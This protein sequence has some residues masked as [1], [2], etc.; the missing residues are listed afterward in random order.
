M[1]NGS[2][3]AVGSMERWPAERWGM[4]GRDNFF[5]HLGRRGKDALQN[6]RRVGI[7]LTSLLT[8]LLN[9]NLA[10]HLSFHMTGF[11]LALQGLPST[12]SS[13]CSRKQ[14]VHLQVLETAHQVPKVSFPSHAVWSPARCG[15]GCR[16]GEMQQFSSPLCHWP[17]SSFPPQGQPSP[18]LW[19]QQL[20]CQITVNYPH[21]AKGAIASV[22]LSSSW[23]HCPAARTPRASFSPQL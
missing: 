7:Y 6:K 21:C 5:L 2:P 12:P 23:P 1:K 15:N 22:S 16:N 11:S 9:V 3:V 18:K 19:C 13:L 17:K 10:L 14:E 20:R 4:W 8:L